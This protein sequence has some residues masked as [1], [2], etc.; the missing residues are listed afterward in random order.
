MSKS[1][2]ETRPPTNQETI[3]RDKFAETI[4]NQSEL[5]DKLAQQ[6]ITLELAI[7]GLYA[8]VLQLTQ[9][10][11]ATVAANG[12]LYGAFGFWFVA[13]LLALVSLIPQRWQVDETLLQRD[14]NSKSEVLG[15]RDFYYASARYKFRW[16]VPSTLCFAA[17]IVCA[18]MLVL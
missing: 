6:L 2:I 5:M 4:V 10:E 7:P 16:L 8:T 17:G 14:P 9:G 11:K 12:W 13:L 18:G 1:P 3:L 15:I